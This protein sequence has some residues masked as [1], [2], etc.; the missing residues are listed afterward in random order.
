MITPFDHH[1][2][3]KLEL[4]K[5]SDPKEIDD[6][7]YIFKLIKRTAPYQYTYEQKRPYIRN[8]VIYSRYREEWQKTYERLRK[9]FGVRIDEKKL[10]EFYDEFRR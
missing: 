10:R 4:N 9:E 6:D 5:V 1:I 8:D 7:Y 3:E 2:F